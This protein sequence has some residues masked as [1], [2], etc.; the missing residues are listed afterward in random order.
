LGG[1]GGG[2]RAGEVRIRVRIVAASRKSPL[3]E[4]SRLVGE[5][6]SWWASGTCDW[7]RFAVACASH[8]GDQLSRW[9][10]Q[11]MRPTDQRKP[12]RRTICWGICHSWRMR[13]PRSRTPALSRP[14]GPRSRRTDTG[15]A[16]TP[17]VPSHPGR[18]GASV[19]SGCRHAECSSSRQ[20]AAASDCVCPGPVC[21]DNQTDP[22]QHA[23]K[24][25]ACSAPWRPP[26]APNVQRAPLAARRAT[27]LAPAAPSAS[28]LPSLLALT[29]GAT[30]G[31]TSGAAS[32]SHHLSP[33][34]SPERA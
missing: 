27:A 21:S 7:G 28:A 17:E 11:E 25:S 2:R 22:D 23:A 20:P 16:C 13:T 15:T 4:L 26:A 19:T 24:N 29:R 1:E 34:N 30:R 10:S 8:M 31:F 6:G 12:H 14:P 18:A 3:L 33:A 32:A 5:V 9:R